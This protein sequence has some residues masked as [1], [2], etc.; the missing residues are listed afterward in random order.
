MPSENAVGPNV[1]KGGNGGKREWDRPV[2]QK[3]PIAATSGVH[4]AN[5]EGGNN[6]T[7]AVA[8]DKS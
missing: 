7:T 6:K 5:N 2:L 4:T 3:L 1:D 8:G